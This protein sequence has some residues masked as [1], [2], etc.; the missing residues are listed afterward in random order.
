MFK[1][2]LCLFICVASIKQDEDFS[3]LKADKFF[4]EEYIN[5]KPSGITNII[6]A[7]VYINKDNK[8]N[9]LTLFITNK[10]RKLD[11]TFYEL[12][13]TKEGLVIRPSTSSALNS[14]GHIS[15]HSQAITFL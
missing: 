13:N 5:G 10:E 6:G 15:L 9:T 2:I 1:Y 8:L 3:Y 4:E 14:R 7:D 12:T 11:V